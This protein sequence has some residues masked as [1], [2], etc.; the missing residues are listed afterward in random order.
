MHLPG[1]RKK[2]I[3]GVPKLTH[4]EPASSYTGAVYAHWYRVQYPIFSVALAWHLKCPPQ[5]AV[6][7]PA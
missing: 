4:S 5:S 1:L 3:K 2:C 7:I 6:H